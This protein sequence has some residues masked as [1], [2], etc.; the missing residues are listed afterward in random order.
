MRGVRL[1]LTGL[2][3]AGLFISCGSSTQLEGVAI[4][5]IQLDGE[6]AEELKG[7]SGK[8]SPCGGSNAKPIRPTRPHRHGDVGM[9]RR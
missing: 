2:L 3:F 1:L 9:G 5:E 6:H 4:H 7:G 8:G